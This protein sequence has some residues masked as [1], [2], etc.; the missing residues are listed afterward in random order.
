VNANDSAA[1]TAHSTEDVTSVAASLGVGGSAGIAGSAGVYV[2]DVT[3]RA[4]INGGPAAA[5]GATVAAQGNVLVAADDALNLNMI[6]GTITGGGSAGVGAAAAVSVVNKQTEAFIGQNA[7]V[8]GRGLRGAMTTRTGAFAVGAV[9]DDGSEDFST[10]GAG[11]DVAGN[12]RKSRPQVTAPGGL[13]NDL[14]GDTS[15]DNVSSSSLTGQRTAVADTQTMRGVAVTASNQDDVETVGFSAGGG[16]GAAVNIGGVVHV[17]STDTRA[18]VDQDAGINANNAGAGSEQSVLVAA[19][20]DY[21]HMGIVATGAIGGTVGVDDGAVVNAAKDVTVGAR[22]EEEILSVALSGSGG[23]SV[24]IGGAITVLSLTDNTRAFIGNDATTDATGAQVNA[25]G[26]VLVA[27]TDDTKTLVADGG[28]GIGIGAAGIGAS[29]AV[30][31]I[32][33]T[34]EAL[35]GDH[36]AVDAKG[37]GSTALTGIHDGTLGNGSFGTL[38]AF[39][40]VAVQASSSEDV[41]TVAAAAGGGLYFGLGGGVAVDAGGNVEVSSSAARRKRCHAGK[42][43][44]RRKRCREP[45]ADN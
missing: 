11:G 32:T 10:L 15:N 12:A 1:V 36:A 40:G 27:A 4:F 21:S 41:T 29:V 24:G 33:K 6:A 2:I 37:N 34:T 23:G 43:A 39:R 13:P 14:S 45:I 7:S 28:L 22:A 30:V 26:N 8:T 5:D 25:G 17:I 44:A 38:A 9:A 16:G 3:T 20:N 19:G 42:G 31:S 18:H 35:I